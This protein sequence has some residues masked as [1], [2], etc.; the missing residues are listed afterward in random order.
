MGGGRRECS[1][2]RRRGSLFT[3]RRYEIV[4]LPTAGKIDVEIVKIVLLFTW[5]QN[6]S[7][8]QHCTSCLR[9][10]GSF[11]CTLFWVSL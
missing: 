4:P 7:L 8:V 1:E 5:F 6:E 2:P 3:L 11:F 10:F 9:R